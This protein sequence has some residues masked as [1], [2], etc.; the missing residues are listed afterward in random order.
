[1]GVSL[2]DGPPVPLGLDPGVLL[3]VPL[4][5]VPVGVDTGD[6]ELVPPGVTLSVDSSEGVAPPDPLLAPVR[7]VVGVVKSV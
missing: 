6:W 2:L 5:G 4:T 1:M 3:P 7:D